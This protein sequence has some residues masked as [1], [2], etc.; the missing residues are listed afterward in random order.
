MVPLASLVKAW[1]VKVWSL[2][3][4]RVVEMGANTNP[5]SLRYLEI[6]EQQSDF[7]VLMVDEPISDAIKTTGII[8][9]L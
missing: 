8:L 9:Q 5:T 7:V 4:T 6:P 2:N 1:V 3:T